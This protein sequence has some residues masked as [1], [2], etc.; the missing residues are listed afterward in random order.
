MAGAT[1]NELEDSLLHVYVLAD[2]TLWLFSLG[3]QG[4][5]SIRG[6]QDSYIWVY[7]CQST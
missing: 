6:I 3:L 7:A 2:N 1:H 5:V 4:R